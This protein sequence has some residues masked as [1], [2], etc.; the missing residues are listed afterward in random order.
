MMAR[1][2]HS[3]RYVYNE[4]RLQSSKVRNDARV[5]DK[6]DGR[7]PTY[8]HDQPKH[9]VATTLPLHDPLDL[10]LSASRGCSGRMGSVPNLEYALAKLLPCWRISK[11]T[12]ASADKEVH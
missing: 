6:G 12:S 4:T 11:A 7:G 5:D 9:A 1:P 3:L 2:R 10:V 8:P